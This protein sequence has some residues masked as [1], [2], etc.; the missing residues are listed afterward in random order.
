MAIAQG[1]WRRRRLAAVHMCGSHSD[2]LRYTPKMTVGNVNNDTL[3]IGFSIRK[4]SIQ[5]SVCHDIPQISVF[6]RK[7]LMNWIWISEIH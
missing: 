6:M 7:M 2:T 5:F 4:F 3:K 1:P